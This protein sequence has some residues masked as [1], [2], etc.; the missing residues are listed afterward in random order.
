[1]AKKPA[2]PEAKKSDV[3]RDFPRILYHAEGHSCLWTSGDVFD[4]QDDG[5]W[6][7]NPDAAAALKD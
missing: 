1:M 3:P 6:A 4:S 2:P 7:S 5:L